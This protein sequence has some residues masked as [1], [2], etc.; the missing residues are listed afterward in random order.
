[1]P[2]SKEERAIKK[3]EYYFKNKDRYRNLNKNYLKTDK[4][5]KSQ[6]ITN[7]KKYGVLCFDWDL[8]YDIFLSTNKCEY[9]NCELSIG[10]SSSSR[11]L[12]H[13]HSIT[14]RFNV[15]GVLCRKCNSADVLNNSP[16]HS[17]Y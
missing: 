15:R 14:D 9:C 12:D 3:S 5:K 17:I 7:W 2:Q 11:C 4:G 10:R 6:R 8:L 13:D 1:M 16:T